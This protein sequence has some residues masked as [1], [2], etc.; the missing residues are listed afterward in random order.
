MSDEPKANAPIEET[1]AGVQCFTYPAGQYAAVDADVADERKGDRSAGAV[2][3]QMALWAGIRSAENLKWMLN[4]MLADR[5]RQSFRESQIKGA[6]KDLLFALHAR[7]RHG[8]PLLSVEE[9][10]AKANELLDSLRG[11]P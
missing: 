8:Y 5:N 11:Q 9:A 7:P 6:L 2:A 4:E 1:L 10:I 3:R